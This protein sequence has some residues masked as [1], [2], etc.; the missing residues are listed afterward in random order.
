[1][2]QV[3]I[4]L[5]N[6]NSGGQLRDTVSSIYE[7]GSQYVKDIVVVDN[8]SHDQSLALIESLV[9]KDSSKLKIIRN[10]ENRGFG[11]ACNQGAAFCK[12][13]YLLFLN[14]D[15]RL[16]QSSLSVPIN[17]MSAP[18]NSNVGICGVQLIDETGG[19]ARSSSRFP[20]VHLF[21][22]QAMGINRLMH[23]R[24]LSH[25]MEEWAHDSVRQVDQV[26]GAYFFI[27]RDLFNQLNGFDEQFFV[28]YE[29]VDV[30][31]RAAKLGFKSIYLSSAQAFHAGGGTSFQIKALRLFYLL[32]S[33]LL[34]GL[35]HFGLLRI[36]ALFVITVLIEPVAR[37]ILALICGGMDD[38]RNTWHAYVMLIKALPSIL[39]GRGV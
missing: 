17:F 34:F 5:V 22:A 13:E 26:I 29:E 9:N 32:R 30:A 19:V 27:R 3:S 11:A 8:N 21:L 12:S 23:L 36:F 4:I 10:K 14:P 18:E 7:Y 2:N 31:Y 6:W 25:T 35:K 39:R 24:H 15:A 33:R 38:V 37:L 28:Y 16:Y 1:M 20:A